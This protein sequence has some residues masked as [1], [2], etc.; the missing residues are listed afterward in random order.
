[1][2]GLKDYSTTPANNTALFPEGMAPSAVNDGMRQVQADLREWYNDAQWVVYGDGDGAFAVAYG[3][4]TSFSVNGADVTGTYHAGRRVKASGALT[5]TIYGTIASSAFAVNTTVSVTWD[6][7]SLQNEPLTIAIGILSATNPAMPP[8]SAG[9]PGAVQLASAVETGEGS[10]AAKAVT[11]AGLAAAEMTWA[12]PHVFRSVD[13]GAAEAVAIDLDRASPTPAANDLLMALRWKM[14][15]A[16]GGTD[17]AAKLVAKL[18]DATAG[19]ED[20]ELQFATLTAGGV[21]ARLILGQ[22][23]Y[24][25][26]ATGGD[27]GG[28]TINAVEIYTR[29][30]PLGYKAIVTQSSTTYT[31]VQHDLNT[32]VKLTN[33]AGCTVTLPS[34]AGVGSGWRVRLWNASGGDVTVQRAGTDPIDGGGTSVRIQNAGGRNFMDWW[35]DGMGWYT[36]KRVF[37]STPQTI[38]SGA[39]LSI[40][41]GLA[42]T[43]SQV[44]VRLRCQT[45][46]AG[47]AVG[48]ETPYNVSKADQN[49][50]GNHDHAIVCDETN[51]TVRFGSAA[52]VYGVANK[53][54]GA[55]TLLTNSNWNVIFHLEY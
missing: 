20:A 42:A 2:S 22:G 29:G 34:A 31:F 30:N 9:A 1:M 21:A 4:P 33:G 6:S 50:T 45:A 55:Q 16:G 54:T 14:R 32:T 35:T 19:S 15:D 46:E 36:S 51:V 24:T 12:A 41:H 49:A 28:D 7:G 43:P 13:S 3:S 53:S 8:A 39:A 27:K 48:E 17:V 18:L 47:Y 37:V 52:N 26:G 10:S 11:P 44:F 25:P 40:A 23:L 38:A 5:G